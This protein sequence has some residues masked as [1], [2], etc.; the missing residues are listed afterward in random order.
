TETLVRTAW[1]VELKKNPQ[2]LSINSKKI[3]VP[4]RMGYVDSLK[5]RAIRDHILANMK[6]YYYGLSVDKHLFIKNKFVIGIECKAYT[7]NAMLKRILVDFHL[8]KT[9]FP[10]L[11]CYLFQLESQLGGDYSAIPHQPKGSSSTHTLMSYFPDVDLNIVTLLD[12]ERK[13]D[14]PINKQKYFKPLGMNR[15][16]S[17]LTVLVNGLKGAAS[18]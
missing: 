5:N 9:K 1:D 13:V 14:Q 7:E 8:L 2:E 3:R 6:S 15:L 17:A 16:E 12:G 10:D 11:A 18:S 4:I